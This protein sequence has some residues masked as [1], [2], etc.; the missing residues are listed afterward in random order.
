MEVVHSINSN[1][2]SCLPY[3]T[4]IY[5]SSI[6]AIGISS[7][8][9]ATVLNSLTIQFDS[10][11]A[12]LS[13]SNF[14]NVE[15]ITFIGSNL[16]IIRGD[17]SKTGAITSLTC[18]S[19]SI[20]D[21]SNIQVDSVSFTL[22]T[23]LKTQT[24]QNFGTWRSVSLV[25][26]WSNYLGGYSFPYGL[27][28]VGS[29]LVELHTNYKFSP[30]SGQISLS[31]LTGVKKI[32][33]LYVGSFS[34]GSDFPISDYPSQMIDFTLSGGTFTSIPSF[35]T[36]TNPG[37]IFFLD[38]IITST[39]GLPSYKPFASKSLKI[40]NNNL[41]GTID[42]SYCSADIYKLNLS[43]NK[44][45]G[46]LPSCIYCYLGDEKIFSALENNAFTN[47][48]IPATPC[49]SINPLFKIENSSHVSL[50]GVNLGFSASNVVS[51]PPLLWKLITPSS[52]YSAEYSSFNGYQKIEIDFIVPGKT[53]TFSLDDSVPPS[54]KTVT[55]SGSK[56]T[57]NGEFFTQNSGS[58]FVSLDSISCTISSLS[59]ELI[60]C[61]LPSPISSTHSLLNV[62]V[63]SLSTSVYISTENGVYLK[64]CLSCE[65]SRGVCNIVSGICECFPEFSGEY[66]GGS[67]IKCKNDCN[68]HG[69]CNTTNGQCHC[70]FPYT[71]DDCSL[72]TCQPDPDCG[73]VDNG[74]C[75]LK[76]G[77]CECKEKWTGQSCTSPAIYAST[78]SS[79][80]TESGGTVE[81]SGWFGPTQGDLI[82]KIGDNKCDII[83]FSQDL[84]LCDLPEGS[85]KKY[86]EMTTT[87]N[88]EVS[89]WKSLDYVFQYASKPPTD[90]CVPKCV[91]GKCVNNKCQCDKTEFEGLDCSSPIKNNTPP[92]GTIVDNNGTS[93]IYN[94][95][96]KYQI[97]LIS[98]IE[99]DITQNPV[100]N[101]PLS[102]N[103]KVIES[104]QD[105]GRTI[106]SQLINNNATQ[107]NFT[108]EEVSAKN[109]P[110][111]KNYSFAGQDFIVSPNSLKIQFSMSNY[112]YFN[113]LNTVKLLMES[114]VSSETKD[115]CNNGDASTDTQE[116]DNTLNYLSISKDNKK[117]YGRFID[118]AIS[119][120]RET[121][122][123]TKI[124]SKTN[125]SV[126]VA[127]YLPH[128]KNVIIDPD[129]SVLVQPSF[130]D[131]CKNSKNNWLIPVVIVVP[132]VAIAIIIVVTVIVIKKNRMTIKLRLNSLNR[133]MSMKSF[134]SKS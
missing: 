112:T 124:E 17:S 126:I 24:L 75:N 94:G 69:S 85:G 27:L 77:K 20:P 73:G 59:F 103:W 110:N 16:D 1:D 68:N 129:F 97:F 48:E 40:S 91:N 37:T 9:P 62:T 111:G 63:N 86:A 19:N 8:T 67:V 98:I 28:E 131:S 26:L 31:G 89:S 114:S 100:K 7:S 130:V 109:Y 99:L 33:F 54:I 134:K 18:E 92:T 35:N 51:R 81:I 80:V 38:N 83:F 30:L 65:S 52:E 49:L 70:D 132:V 3:I 123:S 36:F 107:L 12:T 66:C 22:G 116:T 44:L 15:K 76:Q 119:D 46:T 87:T 34:L 39:S 50:K 60:V 79:N 118:K 55:V 125:S 64:T 43:G 117:L 120:N 82:I 106:F 95:N 93:I 14:L 42:E 57:I 74:Q 108:V 104:N 13:V 2:I 127:I 121:L 10:Y 96:T 45:T 25:T 56:L 4:S 61:D 90:L 32:Q 128:S 11:P 102:A 72:Q 115:E 71:S 5:I 6:R 113:S 53:W 105:T 101:F 23:I 122:I 29:G 133:S 88:S 41:V 84:V 21:L 47:F 78:F 58:T